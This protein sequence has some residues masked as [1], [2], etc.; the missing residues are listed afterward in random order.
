M[1]YE[2]DL[3]GLITLAGVDTEFEIYSGNFSIAKDKIRAFGKNRLIASILALRGRYFD[4][5]FG[6]SS[7]CQMDKQVYLDA[8]E[9]DLEKH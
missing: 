7:G 6:S 1:S 5:F 2:R 9:L 8:K 4:E 3:S